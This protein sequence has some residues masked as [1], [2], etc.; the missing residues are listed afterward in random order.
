[1]NVDRFSLPQESEF[2]VKELSLKGASPRSCEI[3]IGYLENRPSQQR[4]W[5]R[6][7]TIPSIAKPSAQ[8]LDPSR[9]SQAMPRH[10]HAKPSKPRQDSN[11]AKYAR[12]ATD[13]TCASK[14]RPPNPNAKELESPIKII[15][16]PALSQ[17]RTSSVALNKYDTPHPNPAFGDTWMLT[18]R[19][20]YTDMQ[21]CAQATSNVSFGS[22]LIST[23][24]KGSGLGNKNTMIVY[25]RYFGM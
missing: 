18:G 3:G 13:T 15:H 16:C 17:A 20:H 12:L 6:W 7:A 14:E 19:K 5:V 23:L 10:A 24:C 25:N 22:T 4:D 11:H 21:I 2:R 8:H 1:M 9:R